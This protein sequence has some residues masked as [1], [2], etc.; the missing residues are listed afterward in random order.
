[1]NSRRTPGKID[2]ID[3]TELIDRVSNKS[4]EVNFDH[5]LELFEKIETSI[6]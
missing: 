2:S 6:N 1:M 3:I 4:Y 5:S